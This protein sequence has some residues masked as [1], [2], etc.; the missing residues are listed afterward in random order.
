MLVFTIRSGTF[1]PTF[2]RF[3][4]AYSGTKKK[5]VSY[6]ID[7]LQFLLQNIIAGDEMKA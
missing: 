7:Q 4:A 2:M 5:G 6:R 1:K 3:L